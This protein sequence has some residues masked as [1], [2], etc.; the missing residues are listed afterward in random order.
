MVAGGMRM[1]M[2]VIGLITRIGTRIGAGAGVVAA[3]LVRGTVITLIA[4]CTCRRNGAK[5][6]AERDGEDVTG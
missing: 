5:A 4:G 2:I 1:I 6:L 3:T